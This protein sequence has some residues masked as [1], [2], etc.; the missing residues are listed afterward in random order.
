MLDTNDEEFTL[1]CEENCV[2]VWGFSCAPF[3]DGA[4]FDDNDPSTHLETQINDQDV[5]Q[6]EP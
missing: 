6:A 4:Y 5:S 1:S 2:S 3:A